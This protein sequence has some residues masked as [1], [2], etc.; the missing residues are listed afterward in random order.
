MLHSNVNVQIKVR[1]KNCSDSNTQL[2]MF[3]AFNPDSLMG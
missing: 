2:K 1:L 3:E